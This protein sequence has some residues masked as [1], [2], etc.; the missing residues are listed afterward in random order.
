MEDLFFRRA[1]SLSWR[2]R[3]GVQNRRFPSHRRGFVRHREFCVRRR[4]RIGHGYQRG[5]IH[6]RHGISKRRRADPNRKIQRLGSRLFGVNIRRVLCWIFSVVR[7][8]TDN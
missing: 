8:G 5:F 1:F 6:Q 4:Q 7:C 2:F 3:R